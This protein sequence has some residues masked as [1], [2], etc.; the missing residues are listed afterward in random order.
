[1]KAEVRCTCRCDLCDPPG[2]K[3]LAV[4]CHNRSRGCNS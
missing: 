2:P 3:A 4:H 1:M